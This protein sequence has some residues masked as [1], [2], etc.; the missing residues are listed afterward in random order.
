MSNE[1]LYCISSYERV[2]ETAKAQGYRFVTFGEYDPAGGKQIILRHDIV[3]SPSL[4][5]TLAEIDAE[6]GVTS[7]FCAMLDSALYNPL[8]P[9]DGAALCDI[10][11]RGH[12]LGLH[13]DAHAWYE[14]GDYS[15]LDAWLDHG[16]A[17][18]GMFGQVRPLVVSWHSP[19][20]LFR[21]WAQGWHPAGKLNAL[22]R[23][24]CRDGITFIS[25]SN[26]RYSPSQLCEL[27]AQGTEHI[28][29]LL[30]P[31]IWTVGGA[32][33]RAILAHFWRHHVR[34]RERFM[35]RTNGVYRG[36]LPRG[37]SSG[38][39]NALD[40]F[41]QCLETEMQQGGPP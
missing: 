36:D 1:E 11:D 31:L 27:L 4:A 28:Q 12:G 14:D 19:G 37:M 16:Q 20:R 34:D 33:M 32:D 29:L 15:R 22:H 21:I 25:D 23:L 17:I 7:T 3:S 40:W 9:E 6:H 26:C 24:F 39:E 38:A 30:H 41:C 18:L 8:S 35:I 13:L 2:L 10:A 5:R